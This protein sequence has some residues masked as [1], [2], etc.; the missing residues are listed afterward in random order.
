MHESCVVNWAVINAGAMQLYAV[1]SYN[2]LRDTVVVLS[3]IVMLHNTASESSC[4]GTGPLHCAVRL[5]PHVKDDR[6][7][8]LLP[9][10][11]KIGR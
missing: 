7:E 11:P 9:M 2:D 8:F 1:V 10:H 3:D 5:L 6:A 4:S